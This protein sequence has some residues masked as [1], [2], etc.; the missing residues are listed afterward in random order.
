MDPTLK[1]IAFMDLKRAWDDRSRKPR[2]KCWALTQVTHKVR[3]G[4][5]LAGWANATGVALT[6]ERVE[7]LETEELT[8]WPND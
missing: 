4:R 7:Q 3:K 2:L 8:G 6:D 1:N 5:R